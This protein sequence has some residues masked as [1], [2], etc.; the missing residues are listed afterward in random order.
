M[1]L[2]K[3]RDPA[4]GLIILVLVL[5]SAIVMKEGFVSNA[6]WYWVLILTLPLLLL[7]IANMF[8]KR[9]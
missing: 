9:E 7:T 5:V 8:S 2:N 1:T 6:K 3:K 4:S